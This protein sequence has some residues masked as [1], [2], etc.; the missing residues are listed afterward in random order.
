VIADAEQT[1]AAA[2]MGFE[3]FLRANPPRKNAG[4]RNLVVFGRAVTNV[5]QNLRSTEKGFDEW[6]R[7]YRE[8][9]REDPLMRYFYE[10]R[11]SI[12]KEGRLQTT[13]RV[14]LKAFTLPQDLGL[15]GPPPP[16]AES[17]FIGDQLGGAGWV[18]RVSGGSTEKY[19]ADLPP[20]IGSVTI[21]F[22][23]PPTQHLGRGIA[24]T[25]IEN[26]A[27]LYLEYLS[28]LIESAKTAF[29]T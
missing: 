27:E 10:L 22:P 26:L 9:M 15:F 18:V 25:S 16:N 23:N 19:Y 28:R 6:Y 29:L 12:L 14:H 21:A 13:T 4:L 24:D 3:D 8:E 20:D 5:L 17:F 11:S 1:L 2:R 7:K